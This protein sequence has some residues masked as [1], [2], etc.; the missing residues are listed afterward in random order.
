MLEKIENS[1]GLMI[2]LAGIIALSLVVSYFVFWQ[3][4][5][6]YVAIAY[7]CYIKTNKFS[8][9]ILVGLSISSLL[10]YI[11]YYILFMEPA[12]WDY[13]CF[14][15]YGYVA[16]SGLN[17]Y[18]PESYHDILNHLSLPIKLNDGFIREVI[19]V[20]CVYPPPSIFLF[21]PL[22]YFSFM[23]SFYLWKGIQFLFFLI[24]IIV[25]AKTFFKSVNTTNL[26]ISVVFMSLAISSFLTVIYSSKI[27]ILISLLVLA[28]SNS[29]NNKGGIFLS[30]AIF[31]KP[32]AAALFLWFVINK[33]FKSVASFLICSLALSFITFL[34]FGFEPFYEY[35]FNNPTL[36]LPESLFRESGNES[37]FAMFN[38]LFPANLYYAKMGYW[39]FNTICAIAF[40]ILYATMKNKNMKRDIS[41]VL[42]VVFTLFFYPAG[43][44]NYNLVNLIS[45]LILLKHIQVNFSKVILLGL[46]Y[47]AMWR[48]FYTNLFLISVVV[49]II[50]DL[51]NKIYT[52]FENKYRLRLRGLFAGTENTTV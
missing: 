14:Y 44:I 42:I 7:G 3:L 41:W 15:L 50:F 38:R 9:Y 17:F 47:L 20:G 26:M 27:Y 43:G 13:T 5:P 6:L 25:I 19:D 24:A 33:N 8:K 52:L 35:F 16:K 12:L 34:V 31:I 51:E 39:I 32:F 45:F 48:M 1:S 23:E 10:I 11:H 18:S 36:R 21:Y 46:Y 40:I 37:T 4:L 49:F 2:A 30:F 29:D 28:Y 22:G